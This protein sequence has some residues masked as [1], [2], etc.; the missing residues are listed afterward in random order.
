MNTLYFT[1]ANVLFALP[2]QCQ[3]I[4]EKWRWILMHAINTITSS[5]SNIPCPIKN[6]KV[7]LTVTDKISVY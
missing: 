3:R 5:V 6:S 7:L 2:M 1:D 4:L